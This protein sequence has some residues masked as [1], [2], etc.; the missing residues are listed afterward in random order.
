LPGRAKTRVALSDE[1]PVSLRPR[2]A[3]FTVADR[4]YRMAKVTPYRSARPYPRHDRAFPARSA[5][6]TGPSSCSFADET[7]FPAITARPTDLGAYRIDS[8]QDPSISDPGAARRPSDGN[9]WIIK[10]V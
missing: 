1:L 8:D 2:L 10:I 7:R 3:E 5:M 4:P 6:H 9:Y